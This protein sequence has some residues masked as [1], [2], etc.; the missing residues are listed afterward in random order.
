MR[1]IVYITAVC[2]LGAALT[3]LPARDVYALDVHKTAEALAQRAAKAFESGNMTEAATLYREAYKMDPAESAYLYGAAR[4]AHAGR[5]LAHAEED[6][7]TFIG[8]PN[9]DPARVQKAKSYLDTLHSEQS[10]QKA[11]EAQKAADAGDNLL[12]A[13]LF[14]EA[15]RL[16]PDRAEPLLKAAMLERKLGDKKNAVDHLR[17]YLQLAPADAASRGTAETLLKEMGGASAVPKLADPRVAEEKA[18]AEL[19]AKQKAEADKAEAERVKQQKLA[20]DQAAAQKATA[21]RDAKQ[22]AAA[23]KAAGDKAA[24]EQRLAAQK[25]AAEKAAADKARAKAEAAERE[26]REE[27]AERAN[28]H[29][30]SGR[31]IGG[32]TS[33]GVGAGALLGAGILA[34]L[35]SGQQSTLDQKRL[36]DGYFDDSSITLNDAAAQQQGINNKWLGVGILAGAGAVGVGVGAWLVLTDKPA[37]VTVLPR[38]DGFALAGRF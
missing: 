18:K 15:W 2:V 4:A 7:V 14:L 35:A 16:A 24:A 9:A 5:D 23:D 8:L 1:A 34:I 31:R 32:W 26:A 27:A 21:D 33:I 3:C 20:A 30:T 13:T 17:R 11:T 12:A 10:T 28:P 6:Y 29:R 19:A 37:T 36:P 25:V 38:L 22:K